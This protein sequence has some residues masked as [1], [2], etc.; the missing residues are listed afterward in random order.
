MQPNSHAAALDLGRYRAYLLALLARLGLPAYLRP[1]L[2]SSGVVQNTLLQAHQARA[3]LEAMSEGARLAFLRQT[4]RHDLIDEIRRTR[5][6]LLKE[7]RIRSLEAHLLDA[8]GR[9]EVWLQAD[10]PPPGHRL[11]QEEEFLGLA[12]AL[13]ELPEDQRTAVEMKYLQ[14]CSVAEIGEAMGRT[15]TAVGGLLRRGLAKLRR[16]LQPS[17]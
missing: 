6:R 15:E 12:A 1:E 9:A 10:E 5:F 4:L 11:E 14:G 2:D 16:A 13:A 3:R 17:P 7:G 8:S